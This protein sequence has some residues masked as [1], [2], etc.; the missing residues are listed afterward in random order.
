MR[1]ADEKAWLDLR[2][3]HQQ[4]KE[5]IRILRE[6][7]RAT[8]TQ[9][10]ALT[11]LCRLPEELL[12][13]IFSYVGA[14]QPGRRTSQFIVKMS[15]VCR[16]WREGALRYPRLWTHFELRRGAEYQQ[17]TLERS[18]RCL[19]FVSGPVDLAYPDFRLL[20]EEMY[21]VESL[22]LPE[23]PC[24]KTLALF[25]ERAKQ[26]QDFKLAAPHL[27]LF[28]EASQSCSANGS[29]NDIRISLVPFLQMPNLQHVELDKLDDDILDCLSHRSI[30]MLKTLTLRIR[31]HGWGPGGY[32]LSKLLT[33]L[34]HHAPSLNA[35]S[36]EDISVRRTPDWHVDVQADRVIPFQKLKK[37]YLRSMLGTWGQLLQHM[38]MPGLTSV[39]I[40]L[41]TN[42][43]LRHEAA[44]AAPSELLVKAAFL[45]VS[46]VG[47]AWT[48]T[49]SPPID[50]CIE[51]R[52]YGVRLFGSTVPES[53]ASRK[54]LGAQCKFDFIL[55]P[56][57][58]PRVLPGALSR[59][60][61]QHLRIRGKWEDPM[62]HSALQDLSPGIEVL[63]FDSADVALVAAVLSQDPLPLPRL[64]AIH[65]EDCI[66]CRTCGDQCGCG[67]D[68]LSNFFAV[69]QQRHSLGIPVQE[70]SL[71]NSL[72][73]SMNEDLTG[74]LSAAVPNFSYTSTEAGE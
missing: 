54:S 72:S 8:R 48:R 41:H 2:H 55:V 1:V 36:V 61:L 70:L 3:K 42:L 62:H 25:R 49:A 37:L 34:E 68:G 27:T 19:L 46:M 35:L 44:G 73:V 33:A 53:T 50:L 63:T 59:L 22:D 12:A 45:A 30:G 4:I 16:H 28:S 66:L 26:Q 29:A 64:R 20:L 21:R 60:H 11:Y 67:T 65:L 39:E 40:I 58:I 17:M 47:D 38:D 24:Q 57:L 9:M 31:H 13:E 74:K 15:H 6:K 32:R 52:A 56:S 69:L 5:E 10:N 23:V 71:H 51:P 43:P 18:R 14:P 7:M